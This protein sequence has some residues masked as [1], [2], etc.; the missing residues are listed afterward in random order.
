MQGDYY[1]FN[2]GPPVHGY[3]YNGY[4]PYGYPLQA[5]TFI[6]NKPIEKIKKQKQR[7][8]DG[9]KYEDI[10]NS[11]DESIHLVRSR[12]T[13]ESA[14]NRHDHDQKKRSQSGNSI[15]K[16]SA[17]QSTDSSR[18]S[19]QQRNRSQ[20]N[21]RSLSPSNSA[22]LQNNMS[23]D[24][25]HNIKKN[26]KKKDRKNRKGNWNFSDAEQAYT[27]QYMQYSGSQSGYPQT[28]YQADS[29][30]N[31]YVQQPVQQY[32]QAPDQHYYAGQWQQQNSYDVTPGAPQVDC[33]QY[34]GCMQAPAQFDQ[35]YQQPYY[36]D[37]CQPC[38]PCPP[39]P[40][41]GQDQGYQCY[42]L[43]PQPIQQSMMQQNCQPQGYQQQQQNAILP[44]GAKIVAEYFLGYLDEQQPG[45]SNPCQPSQSEYQTQYQTYQQAQSSSDSSKEDV[46]IEVWEKSKKK[47]KKKRDSSSDSSD[48]EKRSKDNG[49]LEKLKD[50]IIKTIQ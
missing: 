42:E 12:K 4:L 28:Q 47:D 14:P 27:Q 17:Q 44:P 21:E 32:Q 11:T 16:N 31:D 3:A 48:N 1:S 39:C 45:Q 43:P 2:Q 24:S 49:D 33:S 20:S 41:Y 36:P 38:P 10:G 19:N 18:R 26:K 34:P 35:G 37:Q 46:D 8:V 25:A 22:V 13:G 15:A 6:T 29:W 50:D 5:P 30:A 9:R 23:T 7:S 40:Q